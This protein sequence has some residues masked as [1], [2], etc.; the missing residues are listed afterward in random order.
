MDSPILGF[1]SVPILD[2]NCRFSSVQFKIIFQRFK[3]SS[4]QFPNGPS[5]VHYFV[6]V[7]AS[8]NRLGQILSK[9]VQF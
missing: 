2:R 1:G 9:S 7:T 6:S 8:P 3:F 5:S 4:V